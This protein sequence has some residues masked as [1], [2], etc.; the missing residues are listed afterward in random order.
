MSCRVYCAIDEDENENQP[1]A[2]EHQLN[3]DRRQEKKDETL[4]KETVGSKERETERDG[5]REKCMFVS[6]LDVFMC[7]LLSY[8]FGCLHT[9]GRYPHLH[10]HTSISTSTSTSTSI[11]TLTSTSVSVSAFTVDGD[12][13]KS[14]KEKMERERTTGK[15]REKECGEVISKGVV[16]FSVLLLTYNRNS[17]D[18]GDDVGDIGDSWRSGEAVNGGVSGGSHC[19]V[20][21]GLRLTR[22]LTITMNKTSTQ[23]CSWWLALHV[24]LDFI[25]LLFLFLA[26]FI[27]FLL[28]VFC[29]LFFVFVEGLLEKNCFGKEEYRYCCTQYWKHR[30]HILGRIS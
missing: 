24:S 14:E 2:E 3:Q 15:E 4:N 20:P 5:K 19:G 10:T 23:G 13:V 18:V 12:N 8:C 16:S 30:S 17:G 11:P 9:R 21:R 6:D 27:Y 7:E 25:Y 1:F 29:F 28:F 22:T 26:L